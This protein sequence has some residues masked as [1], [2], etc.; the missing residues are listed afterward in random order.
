MVQQLAPGQV[1]DGFRLDQELPSGGQSQ[2]WRVSRTG[3]EAPALMK[4]PL[5]R[6]GENPSVPKRLEKGLEPVGAD[7]WFGVRGAQ[8][9]RRQEE[10]AEAAPFS[11]WSEMTVATRTW[12]S[13]MHVLTRRKRAL[14]VGCRR[15]VSAVHQR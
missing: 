1:I 8:T 11:A 14:N 10:R 12:R 6:R 15:C 3:L 7:D 4:I 9:C 5:L 13:A 2:F